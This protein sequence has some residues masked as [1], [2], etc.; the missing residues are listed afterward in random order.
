MNEVDAKKSLEHFMK[1]DDP[2]MRVKLGLLWL[3]KGPSSSSEVPAGKV[4]LDE[5]WVHR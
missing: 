3:C 4:R 5:N 1:N 2:D